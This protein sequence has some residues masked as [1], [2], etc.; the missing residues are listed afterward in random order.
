MSAIG[1]RL[2]GVI[3]A[4][5]LQTALLFAALPAN[6][7]ERRLDLRWPASRARNRNNI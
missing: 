3:L 4:C 6:P 1:W 2:L 5:V 7:D